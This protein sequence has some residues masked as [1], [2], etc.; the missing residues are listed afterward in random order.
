MNDLMAKMISCILNYPS[1]VKEI[2]SLDVIEERVKR[3]PDSKLLLEVIENIDILSNEINIDVSKQILLESFE[4]NTKIYNKLKELSTNDPLL[5]K[6]NAKKEFLIALSAAENKEIFDEINVNRSNLEEDT[7]DD[8]K[9]R[10]EAVRNLHTSDAVDEK[11]DKEAL[12]KER[13]SLLTENEKLK[14][15]IE[16][17][18]ELLKRDYITKDKAKSDERSL[19]FVFG[20]FLFLLFAWLSIDGYFG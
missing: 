4:D 3:L 11:L 15:H 19:L 17:D 18:R 8:W 16:I 10:I 7:D 12:K 6:N 13:A 20:W 5:D 1:L 2:E 14:S 9:K